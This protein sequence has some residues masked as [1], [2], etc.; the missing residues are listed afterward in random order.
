[1]KTFITSL[2]LILCAYNISAQYTLSGTVKNGTDSS[3]V[4]YATVALMTADSSVITGTMSGEDGVFGL[5][6]V[7]QGFYRLRFTC[8][9]YETAFLDVDVPQQSDLGEIRLA[10]SANK[11][12]EVVVTASSPLIE[13]RMD[14]YIVNVGSHIL[15][16]G[17]NALEVLGRTPGLL[18]SADGNIT[19]A[20][21]AVEVWID[22]RPSNLSGE[23][24]K[25]M[26][27]AMQGEAI[28]RVEV[29][30]NPSSRYDAAGT[31][32]IV[33]I[34]T[35]R[36][37]QYGV[38]GS[39][40]AGYR[41]SRVAT[42][43]AGLQL[44]YRSSAVNLF[45]N[46]GINRRNSYG[47]LRQ[48]NV[49][50]TQEGGRVTFDQYTE[51]KYQTRPLNH[52]F[53]L[54]GDF[55]LSAGSTLGFLLNDYEN[56]R[57]GESLRNGQTRITP[58]TEEGVSHTEVHSLSSGGGSGRQANVNFQQTFSTP[59]QQLNVDLDVA[60]FASNPSQR[61]TNTYFGPSGEP[62]G[63]VEQLRHANPQ[64]IDIRSGRLDYVQP[65]R[66]NATL[67]AGLKSSRSTTDNDLSYEEF[68]DGNWAPDG[69]RSNRFIYTEQIHAGYLNLS[70]AWEKWS[71]QAGL[72]G[73]YTLSK[74]E[75]RTV[76]AVVTD[77]SYFDLFPALFVNYAPQAEA[78]TLSFSYSRR[79]RRPVYSQLNPFEIKLDAYSYAAGNPYLTPNYRHLFEL[80]YINRHSLM[81]TLS[82]NYSTDLVVQTPV[83]DDSGEHLRYG[84][85]PTNFGTRINFGG[86][87]NYRFSPL[88][89]WRVNCMAD[90]AYVMNR[91]GD[92]SEAFKN[93]GILLYVFLNNTLN[94]GHGF[95]AEV[96]GFYGRMRSGYVESEPAA[97]LS[98][99]L[100]KSL[101]KDKLLIS[102]NVNDV[103]NSETAWRSSKY[104]NVDLRIFEDLD[105][106]S[107]AL[108]V[109]YGFGSKTVKA[110]RNRTSGIEDEAGRAK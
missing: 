54:G 24:L 34:R 62:A 106:R 58:P 90:A 43:N 38:N 55:F 96:S 101:M 95:S 71:V 37:L 17:R 56:G 53:R 57:G 50:D 44:N 83:A 5:E 30:T 73:E 46:Y 21:N 87:V 94:L 76:G 78:F 4:A 68:L 35:R 97:S 40:N 1:M 19:L 51:S 9:G 86:M 16:A 77:S 64:S 39:A 48:V 33:N 25:S 10:E 69:N 11:L 74:G 6:N 2:S 12:Q 22:G 15:T 32:G 28:D 41:L 72:R 103:F 79:L 92:A 81:V 3:A 7:G 70:K 20:G 80:A 59:G 65:L 31:G 99:G 29:I 93:D 63:E 102:L 100:R 84:W 18:V 67:E 52:Q 47:S 14:R 75:Q 45:G 88:K 108:S 13:R 61:V 107:V 98:T 89:G 82:Y 66:E 105:S 110:S 26:L 104:R 36:G 91:S 85:I 42:E 23:Q 109:R 60:R 8:I 49:V 27:T